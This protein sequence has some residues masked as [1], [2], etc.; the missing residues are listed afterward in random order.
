MKLFPE[1]NIFSSG[2]I[3]EKKQQFI[4]FFKFF[5]FEK[6]K[7]FFEIIMTGMSEMFWGQGS[8]ISF[9]RKDFGLGGMQWEKVYAPRSGGQKKTAARKFCFLIFAFF[10]FFYYFYFLIDN[11]I[12]L[13]KKL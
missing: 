11:F 8:S 7:I 2:A 9:H 6:S 1:K 4:L 13:F 12:I 3:C 5:F 10:D